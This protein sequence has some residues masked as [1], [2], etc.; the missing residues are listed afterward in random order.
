MIEIYSEWCGPCIPA[1]TYFKKA[2]T[3]ISDDE[4]A[5]QFIKARIRSLTR[6]SLSPCP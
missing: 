1:I 5:L 2:R 3:E 6:S 4:E